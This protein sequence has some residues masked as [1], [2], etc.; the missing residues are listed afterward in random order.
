M[1]TVRLIPWRDDFRSE[2]FQLA[3]EGG[4]APKTVQTWVNPARDRMT[5]VA[6]FR[7]PDGLVVKLTTRC[8]RDGAE[9]FLDEQHIDLR[10]AFGGD[11]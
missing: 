5:L 8:R 6:K 1:T 10:L 3:P 2:F 11:Q 4:A 7:R 9:W